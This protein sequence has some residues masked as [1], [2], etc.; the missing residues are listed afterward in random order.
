MEAILDMDWKDIAK[1]AA[2]TFLQSF[3][4]VFLLSGESFIDLIFAA[5]WGSLSALFW[6]TMAGAIA[7]GLSALKTVIVET[8]RVVKERM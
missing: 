4:A 2:W 6:S 1:R 8:I 5:D 3:F 7:A